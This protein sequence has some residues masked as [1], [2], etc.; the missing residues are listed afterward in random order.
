MTAHRLA[1][2]SALLTIVL[3]NGC[4]THRALRRNT[5]KQAG[6]VT[7]IHQ[8]QVLDNLAKFLYDPYAVPSFA[9]ATQG[10][11]DV[12]DNGQASGVTRWLANG[13]DN[14]SLTLSASRT[15]KQNWVMRPVTD[16]RKLELMRCAYQRVLAN[17]GVAESACCPDC[18]KRFNKFYTGK[19]YG[20][21]YKQDGEVC[22]EL[23]NLVSQSCDDGCICSK[24][25]CESETSN[26]EV[27]PSPAGSSS[28]CPSDCP[29]PGNGTVNSECLYP[30][31]CWFRVGKKDRIPKNCQL[32]GHYCG[33]YI[34]V[35]CGPGRDKLAHLTLAILD[36]AVHE[37]AELPRKKVTVYLDK[38]R[39]P[40]TREYAIYTIEANLGITEPSNVLLIGEA[41]MTDKGMRMQDEDESIPMPAP[42]PQR[43]TLTPGVNLL[44]QQQLL[45]TVR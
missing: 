38:E 4:T 36:Y 3:A 1:L 12:T 16:P 27:L 23:K 40:V 14:F 6:T 30:S 28:N 37:S 33:T 32:V 11:S 25:E 43:R 18:E 44:R 9:L 42:R 13:F 2:A 29:Q 26:Q 22:Y 8:Q 7:D 31:C 41:K 39:L 24:C 20:T 35:P 19:A 17:C 15:A 5:I 21:K 34:W 45:D 10:A